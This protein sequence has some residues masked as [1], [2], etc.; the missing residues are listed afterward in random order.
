FI[1]FRR[2][3]EILAGFMSEKSFNKL[4]FRS[5]REVPLMKSLL[6]VIALIFFVTALAGPRWG[7]KFENLSIK[8]IEMIFL[9]DTS[10]SMNA[11]DIKPDRFAVA[12]N[13]INTIVDNLETDYVGLIKFAGTA[14]VQCPLTIDYE[15]MK[16][17]T[18]AA[19]ISP[20]E[21]QGTDFYEALSLAL[22]AGRVSSNSNKIIFLITDGEDQEERW[23]DILK[24]IKSE[25]LIIFPIGIGIPS[26]A[27]IPLRDESGN[28]KGWKKDNE[29]NMVRTK[30][31][32]VVLRRIASETG[33]QYFR[34]TDSAG[35]EILLNNL[36]TFERSVLRKKV[37]SVKIERFHYPLS[38]GIILLIIELLL[39]EKKIKW[40]RS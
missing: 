6:I 28:M 32:E 15:A 23:E 9:L 3:H 16:L 24:E 10:F 29:G 18:E 20:P 14:H 38:I 40:K 36:K 21:E 22:K 30:L 12:K 26:G 5:G 37:R 39:I 2:K 25:K 17:L 11:E 1:N 4:G 8:G 33:G 31:N 19:E 13:L 35:M 7:E 27:P 34:L